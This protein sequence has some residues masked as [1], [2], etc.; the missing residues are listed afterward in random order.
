MRFIV[1]GKTKS[2]KPVIFGVIFG[3]YTF[4]GWEFFP[5]SKPG[6]NTGLG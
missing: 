1:I 2:L 3:L 5:Q 4:F 6:M